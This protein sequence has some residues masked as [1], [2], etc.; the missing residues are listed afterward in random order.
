M[1]TLST[2]IL[3]AAVGFIAHTVNELKAENLLV[4]SNVAEGTHEGKITRLTDAVISSK[5]LLVEIGS[6][7][8]HVAVCNSANDIPLGVATDEAEAA[9]DPVNVALLGSAAS[10][11]VVTTGAAVT[12]GDF[13]TCNASGQAVKLTAT[14]GA[15]YIIGR[16]LHS[17]NS[18]EL[19]EFDPT[20]PVQRVVV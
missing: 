4:F 9:G 20:V 2:I 1:I 11:L 10:T 17:S 5:Y 12:E 13:L 3:L 15:Y 7:G 8:E 18:G 14:P 16:A 6:D 19:V